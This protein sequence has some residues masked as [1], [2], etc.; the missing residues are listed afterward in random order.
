M[1]TIARLRA[2]LV[3][4]LLE[5]EGTAPRGQRRVAYDGV[6]VPEPL[7]AVIAKVNT[8]PWEVADQDIHGLVASGQSEDQVFELVV[9]AAV[10]QA[11][12]QYDAALAALDAACGDGGP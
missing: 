1:G 2:E 4:R 7:G 5:G 10:G 11:G 3:S 6:D 8:R 9:C 12:R